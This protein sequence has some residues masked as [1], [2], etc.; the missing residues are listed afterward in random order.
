MSSDDS[1]DS[2]VSIAPRIQRRKST[3]KSVD[4]YS[5]LIFDQTNDKGSLITISSWGKHTKS[6][7]A[8]NH[9]KYPVEEVTSNK[10]KCHVF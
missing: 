9:I 5:S 2:I 4:P 7:N 6:F 3:Y 1:D 10:C 8:G